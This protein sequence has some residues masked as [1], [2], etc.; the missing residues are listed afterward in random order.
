MLCC[1]YFV[2]LLAG[3]ESRQ[4]MA[5]V[6]MKRKLN[7]SDLECGISEPPLKKAKT[8]LPELFE[9]EEYQE[10]FEMV[11][12]AV[13]SSDLIRQLNVPSPLSQQIAFN[14]IGREETCINKQ[15]KNKIIM[16]PYEYENDECDEKFFR[17]KDD[18]FYEEEGY[19]CADC[20]LKTRR[21]DNC[22]EWKMNCKR[23]KC[24]CWD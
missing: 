11:Y 8:S 7:E 10:E 24:M 6:S 21:C 2:V 22:R 13:E 14:V 12:N 5:T 15:C 23:E 17:R 19:F 20:L 18:Q 3:S 1:F 9:C 4:K 16:P